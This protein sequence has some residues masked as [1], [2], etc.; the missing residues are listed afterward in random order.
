MSPDSMADY[1]YEHDPVYTQAAMD[2]ME[3]KLEDFK[4]SLD[5]KAIIT[6]EQLYDY[7][8]KEAYIEELR[9]G[10]AMALHS[11]TN[12]R[13]SVSPNARTEKLFELANDLKL[14]LIKA[15][16]NNLKEKG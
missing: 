11:V 2:K 15:P 1:H 16:A 12:A 9:E 8:A 14:L 6:T 4:R 3:A 7:N 13:K 10:I 5:G